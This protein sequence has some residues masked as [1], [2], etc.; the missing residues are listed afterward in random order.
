MQMRTFFEGSAR[1][2]RK[3]SNQLG[4]SSTVALFNIIV[5]RELGAVSTFRSFYAIISALL[6]MLLFGYFSVSQPNKKYKK[7]KCY[8]ILAGNKMTT[9]L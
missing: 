8:V 9:F 1:R 5:P 6:H 7:Q 2:P 3:A 4:V